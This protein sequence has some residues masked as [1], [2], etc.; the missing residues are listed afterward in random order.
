MADWIKLPNGEFL[1]LDRLQRLGEK[2]IADLKLTK[3]DA[4]Y[5]RDQLGLRAMYRASRIRGNPGYRPRFE[6]RGY[7]S[8]NPYDPNFMRREEDPPS[9]KARIR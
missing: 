8:N 4:D 5:L 3:I 9:R 2:E 6:P 1:N 7:S